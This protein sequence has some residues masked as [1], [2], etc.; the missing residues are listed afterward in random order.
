MP[1]DY[2]FDQQN[3]DF[4]KLQFRF[5]TQLKNKLAAGEI[6]QDYYDNNVWLTK[7]Q[8]ETPWP[9][10]SGE[11]FQAV[12][13]G[14][15]LWLANK[16]GQSVAEIETYMGKAANSVIQPAINAATD[17]VGNTISSAISNNPKT[18][19]LLGGLGLLALLAVG[20]YIYLAVKPR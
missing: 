19:A 12:D 10:L 14:D 1:T 15:Y 7:Q 18:A 13:N 20:A 17:A 3:K 11:F 9:G 5:A 16:V 8:L 4:L 6:T 2:S